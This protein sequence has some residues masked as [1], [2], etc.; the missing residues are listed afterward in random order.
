MVISRLFFL[1][2][3]EPLLL[4]KKKK[5]VLQVKVNACVSVP[6]FSMSSRFSDFSY[7][8]LLTCIHC[9]YSFHWALSF[10]YLSICTHN[11]HFIQLS[12]C[13][14]FSLSIYL[15]MYSYN[16][17][18]IF[19]Q[20][21]KTLCGTYCLYINVASSQDG[22]T[23]LQC[24]HDHLWRLA[25]S[26]RHMKQHHLCYTTVGQ[27]GLVEQELL[28]LQ[29][30]LLQA[31]RKWLTCSRLSLH[32]NPFSLIL[33]YKLVIP[34]L[35]ILCPNHSI[36]VMTTSLL[37]RSH[38]FKQYFIFRNSSSTEFIDLKMLSDLTKGTKGHNLT[39]ENHFKVIENKPIFTYIRIYEWVPYYIH[40]YNKWYELIIHL[41]C[42]LGVP[43]WK[44]YIHIKLINNVYTHSP[45]KRVTDPQMN[46][47]TYL[48]HMY[49][50]ALIC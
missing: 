10:L 16:L 46:M 3:L 29:L 32:L 36:P 33:L 45:L 22:N 11:C 42:H 8:I 50:T 25:T 14:S 4:Q 13:L 20:E 48:K 44:A 30:L 23:Q 26:S 40:S 43:G 28:L 15:S 31:K 9:H 18:L 39:D 49:L 19:L 47:H 21:W 2:L 17:Q 6:S 7:T 5:K 12:V 27:A 38:I 24:C 35:F 41:T 37:V 1:L 34:S